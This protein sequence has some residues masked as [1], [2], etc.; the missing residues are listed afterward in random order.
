L[1]DGERL[2][3]RLDRLEHLIERLEEVRAEGLESYLED[4][5]LRAKA[6]RWLQLAIQICIDV[7]AQFLSE[8]SA[9]PPSDYAGV[10]TALAGAGVLG[11]D[12]AERL[13]DAAGQRNLLVHAYLEIDDRAIFASLSRLDD[14]RSFARVAQRAAD[15]G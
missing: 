4:E 7:G 13:A 3:A 14:L 15:E 1:V 11:R 5:D 10:F 6:E 2:G 9:R 8:V 12:H